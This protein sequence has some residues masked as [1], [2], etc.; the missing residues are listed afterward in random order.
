LQI[1][2]YYQVA[3]NT[4]GPLAGC[5]FCLRSEQVTGDVRRC[6]AWHIVILLALQDST[7]SRPRF[8]NINWLGILTNTARMVILIDPDIPTISP[9]TIPPQGIWIKPC[10][11]ST[12]ESSGEGN[13]SY[14]FPLTT[15]PPMT[16][17]WKTT[18][19][20]AIVKVTIEARALFYRDGK[21]YFEGYT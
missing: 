17:T 16:I 5:V 15:T 12:Q 9:A 3:Y 13:R 19:A 1:N 10:R 18:S 21:G 7:R 11:T 20:S 6:P 2:D 4:D 14:R 8:I